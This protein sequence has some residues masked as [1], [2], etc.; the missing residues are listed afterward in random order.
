MFSNFGKQFDELD[1]C[2]MCTALKK[3]NT[4]VEL[5]SSL[6]VSK[7]III[8]K[9]NLIYSIVIKYTISSYKLLLGKYNILFA[10]VNV[11]YLDKSVNYLS[12]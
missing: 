4:V 11:S 9:C 12:I 3:L 8:I 1:K 7:T 6:A 10:P 5:I 2:H